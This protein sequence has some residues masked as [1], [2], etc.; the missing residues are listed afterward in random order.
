MKLSTALFRIAQILLVL[1]AVYLALHNIG[2]WGWFLFIFVL[3]L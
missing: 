3:T 1:S 2:G